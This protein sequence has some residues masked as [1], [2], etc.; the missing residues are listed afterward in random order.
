MVG[1]GQ[2]APPRNRKT[3]PSHAPFVARVQALSNM[4]YDGFATHLIVIVI[5]VIVVISVLI[6]VKLINKVRDFPFF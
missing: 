6:V 5:V 3:R 4:P 2:A 1:H